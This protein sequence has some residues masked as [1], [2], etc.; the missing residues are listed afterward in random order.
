M[1]LVSV[2]IYPDRVGFIATVPIRC[3]W[4][5]GGVVLLIILLCNSRNAGYFFKSKMEN[6]TGVGKNRFW[7]F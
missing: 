3:H 6:E 1:K 7:S 4:A 2:G 5:I